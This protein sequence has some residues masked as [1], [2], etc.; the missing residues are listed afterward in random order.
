[1]IE[2][3]WIGLILVNHQSVVPQSC[4]SVKEVKELKVSNDY[5]AL[6]PKTVV[7]ESNNDNLIDI[8]FRDN[9]KSSK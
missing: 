5:V 2:Y 6:E 1:M 3:S 8:F 7:Q 4:I 9:T